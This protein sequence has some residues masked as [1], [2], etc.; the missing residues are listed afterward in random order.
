MSHHDKPE[1]Y[2]VE[3]ENDVNGEIDLKHDP[4]LQGEPTVQPTLG[5]EVPNDKR[6]LVSPLNHNTMR[7]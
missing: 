5:L 3:D 2:E 6:K 1:I 7:R 4:A